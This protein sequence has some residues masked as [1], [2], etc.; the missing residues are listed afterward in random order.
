MFAQLK[1]VEFLM[2]N[3][4]YFAL[5]V[6]ASLAMGCP[7]LACLT[8]SVLMYCAALLIDHHI[9]QEFDKKIHSSH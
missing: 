2:E 8:V 5:T 7:F 9:S 6:S 1:H 3:I 4:C